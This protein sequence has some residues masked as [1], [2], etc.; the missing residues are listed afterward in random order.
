MKLL[1][2]IIGLNAKNKKLSLVIPIFNCQ[3]SI[4]S[5]IWSI[6]NQNMFEIEI[7]LLSF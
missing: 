3:D 7:I 6:Q 5:V 2:K 1:I 4:L